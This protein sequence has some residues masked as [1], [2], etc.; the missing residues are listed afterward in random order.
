MLY[1]KSMLRFGASIFNNTLNV[2]YLAKTLIQC[3]NSWIYRSFLK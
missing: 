3:Q 1:G 2:K